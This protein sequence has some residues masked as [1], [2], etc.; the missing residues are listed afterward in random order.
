MY[1]FKD[2]EKQVL[3]FWNKNK[4]YSKLKKRNSKGKPF[5]FLQGPPYTSGRIHIGSAWNYCLKDQIL[6]YKRMRGFDVWDRDGYDMHGLPTENKVQKKLKIADKKEIE[7]YGVDKFVKECKKFSLETMKIMID[8]FKRLGVW[9]DFDDPYMPIKNEFMENEWL[10]IKKADEKKRLY[11]GEKVMTWCQDCETALAKHELEY[12]NV[13]DDSIFVKFKVKG[14]NNEYLCLWTTTPWTICFNLGVMVNP[15]LDYVKAK[16]GDEVWILAKALAAPVIQNFTDNNLEV[17][18]EF[19]GSK[20]KGLRYEHPFYDTLKNK[21]DEIIK[22]YPNAFTVVLSERYV[23]TSAGT[24]LVHMAVGC[25]PEDYEVGQENNIPPFNNLDEKGNYPDDMGEFSGLNVRKDNQKFTE[26]LDKRGALI[27]TTKVEH[28]YPHCWRC[29]NP[30]IFKTTKQWFFKI[31]DLIPK[32]LS[33]SKK[34]KWIPK[35]YEES[36]L[37]WIE[38]LRDNAITR[39]RYW[40]TPIPL[41]LCDK[42]GEKIVVDSV[43]ELKKYSK[44]IPKDLHKPW[45]DKVSFKC[46]K[47]SGTMRRL[48]DVLDVWLDSGTTSWN[49]L[50][51][52]SKLIKK[53]FPADIILEATEQTRL[54]FYTLQLCSNIVFEKNPYNNVYLHGMVRDI[55]GVKMSKSLGNIISPYEII[56]KY[57]VDTFRFYFNSL[58]AGKDVN[59]SWEEIKIKFRNLGVLTNT[60]TYLINYSG[61]K[62]QSFLRLE[63]KWILSRANS[64]IKEVTELLDEYKIDEIVSPIEEL[65]LDLSRTYIH[66][67]RDRIEEKVVVNTI[68]ESILGILKIFSIVCPFITE[69]IYQDL[70]SKFKLKEDSV[71]L[72]KW[73]KSNFKLINKKL[74]KNMQIV[75]DVIQKILFCREKEQLGVRWPLSDVI[76]Y[77]KKKEVKD[78]IKQ[79]S[80]IIKSQTN[81]KKITIKGGKEEIELN[82]KLTPELEK[83]GFT[84]EVIRR[85][86]DLR[87]KAKL[88]KEDKINLEIES[89]VDLEH[90][91]IEKTVNGKLNKI[92]KPKFEEKFKIKD[93]EFLIKF[94]TI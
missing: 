51:N 89:M 35:N 41:W 47:C 52:D 87:K 11:L 8:D 93:K 46:K 59:F 34:V 63:D 61:A 70:K 39:Q 23:D 33:Q 37:R 55:E 91:L 40:G 54:W 32:F 24:G 49:S 84:R 69:K 19:K 81:V 38:N 14:K 1:N 15:K 5:Y 57:G 64:T 26:A 10:L 18:E 53:Y 9:L 82:T 30:V 36:Y 79:L 74:E 86:Q 73:P 22:K 65:F 29:H 2:T 17:I 13:K 12:K 20:L 6:R 45:I 16:V 44:D 72:F 28:D 60:A 58:N 50:K 21:Y 3:E 66:F 68:K 78:A 48:P 77:T 7:K 4:I 90:K 71:H 42:C 83:E 56:D 67:I 94:N 88:N 31:E 25:G 62:K 85:V 75:R 80:S 43:K 76:I 92:S 27:A